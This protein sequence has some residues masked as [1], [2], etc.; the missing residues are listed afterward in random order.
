MHTFRGPGI[1][2]GL[3]ILERVKREFELP[4]L[5]DVHS[6]E[7]A[8]AAAEICD[9]IQIPAFLCIKLTSY[10]CSRQTKAI[11]NIKKG[12]FMAPWDMGNAVQR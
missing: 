12:Q 10:C 5:T 1:Q 2:E 8:K 4:I 11:V 9:V 7:D 6:P 3:R